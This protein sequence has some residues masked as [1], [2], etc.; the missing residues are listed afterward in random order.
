M[1]KEVFVFVVCGSREHIET[2]HYSLRYLN[3]F[4]QKEIFVLTDSSRNEIE[5]N[6]KGIIDIPVPKELDHHQASIYLKTGIYKFVPKG[7]LYCY[8][9]TDVI[10]LSNKCDS[11]FNEFV[12]PIRFAA[13][14]CKIQDFSAYAVNCDCINK[15]EKDRSLFLQKLG[16]IDKN[17]RLSSFTQRVDRATIRK[18]Y[19]KLE[20]SPIKKLLLAIKYTLS[21][22]N[23]KLNQQFTLNKK[24]KEWRNAKGE[25]VKYE[26]NYSALEE[27]SKVKLNKWKGTW[28]NAKNENIF[29]T[30]CNHLTVQISETFNIEVLNKDFQ[31]WNGGVFLFNDFSSK[32]LESWHNK[33]MQIFSLENWKT[34]DQG[35]LIATAWEFGL[36]NHPVLDKKWN[37]IA[38]YYNEFLFCDLEKDSITDDLFESPFEPNFIHVYHHWADQN[39]DVWKWIE[40]KI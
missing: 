12:A 39:W 20:S 2:L 32:F 24:L 8:L 3:K 4:S 31:H 7:N 15:C 27:A 35:T 1:S 36:Q 6:H 19:Q 23:F 29:N 10:A 34:R 38:D 9:D 28:V 33:T 16:E 26:L 25:L 13:D 22:K 37:F 11:I 14:H 30:S 40:N 17:N 21:V 5:I 18:E